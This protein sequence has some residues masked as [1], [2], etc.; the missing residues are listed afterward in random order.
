M[1]KEHQVIFLLK[2]LSTKEK[3]KILKRLQ[4]NQIKEDFCATS[5]CM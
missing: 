1:K 3:K 2:K 5:F 4:K